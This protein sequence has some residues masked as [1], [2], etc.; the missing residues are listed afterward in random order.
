MSAGPPNPAHLC[1][2][3]HLTRL[4]V[5]DERSADLVRGGTGGSVV[6]PLGVQSQTKSGLDAR[7]QSLG[8]RSGEDTGVVDL[9]L[10]GGG[11]VQ[12]DLGTDF[13]CDTPGGGLGVV[14]GLGTGLDVLG[15]LVVVRGGEGGQV[16]QTVDGDGVVLKA[17][18]VGVQR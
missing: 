6:Q 16:A 1:P 4:A 17:V 13:E 3:E 10:D 15:N 14:D 2:E 11:V 8:V 5:E 18:S 7:S 9:E 12:V